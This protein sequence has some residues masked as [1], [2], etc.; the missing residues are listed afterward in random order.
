MSRTY[1]K[2]HN[3]DSRKEWEGRRKNLLEITYWGYIVDW[4][5]EK[6]YSSYE[7]HIKNASRDGQARGWNMTTPSWYN[8]DYH[9]K[10]RRAKTR[11]AIQQ[12]LKLADYEDAPEFPLDKKP[13]IYYW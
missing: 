7:M 2:Y 11:K 8:R 12:V 4:Y 6:W 10:P 3:R 1:R 9:T 5:E 13:H